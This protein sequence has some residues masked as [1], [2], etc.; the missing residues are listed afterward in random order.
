MIILKKITNILKSIDKTTAVKALACGTVMTM[1]LSICGFSAKYDNIRENVLRLHVLANSDS[2]EDQALKLKVRDAVLE[3]SEGIFSGCTNEKEAAVA[4]GENIDL[5]AE[6]AQNAVLANG[7]S[8]PVTVEVADTW[9][10]NRVYDDFTLPAGTYE[11]LRIVIG[12]GEGHNWWCVMFPA[13][14]I[15]AAVQANNI[16]DVLDETETDMVEQPQNYV[17][18]FKVVELFEKAK[19]K[20]SGFFGK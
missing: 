16:S 11:A 14:C 8:Y 10:N 19:V 3:I 4:A 6:V 13:V 5:I 9:F 1:T 12:S 2:E 18:R 20:L 17:A 15:P 7:Y